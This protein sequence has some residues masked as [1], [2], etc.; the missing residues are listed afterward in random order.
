MRYC[1]LTSFKTGA[2]FLCLGPPPTLNYHSFQGTSLRHPSFLLHHASSMSAQTSIACSPALPPCPTHPSRIGSPHPY[3]A[4][5]DRYSWLQ[6]EASY[7][8]SLIF[9]LPQTALYLG[10][11]KGFTPAFPHQQNCAASLPHQ[12]HPETSLDSQSPSPTSASP[13]CIVP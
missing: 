11:Q 4:P 7:L 5:L 9:H 8:S 6:H 13:P 1:P 3:M 2:L 10:P 12:L